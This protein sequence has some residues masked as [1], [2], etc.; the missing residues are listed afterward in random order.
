MNKKWVNDIFIIPI[1]LFYFKKNKT[2]NENNNEILIVDNEKTN[3]TEFLTS[4]WKKHINNYQ[5]HKLSGYKK[6][7]RNLLYQKNN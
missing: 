1:D 5:R 6:K 2:N 3:F 7:I 4:N